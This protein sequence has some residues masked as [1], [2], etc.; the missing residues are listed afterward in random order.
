MNFTNF[1]ENPTKVAK[2]YFWKT[3]R[4]LQFQSGFLLKVLWNTF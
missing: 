3:T 2:H 1:F 4:K